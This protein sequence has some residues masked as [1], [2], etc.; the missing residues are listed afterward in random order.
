[1]RSIKDYLLLFFKGVGIGAAN[2][3]PGVSGGTIAFI[4]NIYEELI[5]SL[6]SIDL[7]AVKLTFGFKVKELSQHINLP[8][9]IAVFL[10]VAISILSLGKLLDY[11]FNVYPVQVWSFFFGLIL[12]SIFFVGKRIKIWNAVVIFMLLLGTAIAV[13]ISFLKPASENENFIYL[14]LCGV[15]AISSMLLPGLSGSFVLILLGNYHLLFL[16]AI[17][18][19]NLKIIM[20]VGIGAVIGF[21]GLSHLIAFVLKKFYDATIAIL[22]GFILG[23]LLI[24]WPWKHAIYLEDELG[25]YVIKD[26]EKV[27]QSYEHFIPQITEAGT[28]I[29]IG[30]MLLG[31]VAVWLIES[32]GEKQVK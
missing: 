1:M 17:P 21:V 16:K 32:F 19:F 4:T 13:Y 29:A 25:S 6:K 7:K 14:I 8:F 10:G 27:I 18:D 9:L 12:A 26:G 20:P 22:T 23:S 30:L 24:I 11:L 2:V 15:V 31:I 3:I 28:L 5:D